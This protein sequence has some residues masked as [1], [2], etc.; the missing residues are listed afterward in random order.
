MNESQPQAPDMTYDEAI[1][2]LE[3]YV[4][5]MQDD[6][7]SIDK[8]SEY[9]KQSQQLLEFCRRKLTETDA[10]LQKILADIQKQN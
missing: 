6:Q 5:L 3:E 7:C 4:S 2:K 1:K 8:L 9:T 10:E